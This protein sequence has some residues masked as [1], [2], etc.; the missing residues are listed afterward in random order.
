MRG[1]VYPSHRHL[2]RVAEI[3]VRS[4][5]MSTWRLPRASG[6][7][8]SLLEMSLK[9]RRNEVRLALDFGIQFGPEKH[10]NH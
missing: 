7:P 2:S 4:A 5:T 9:G 10:D 6:S 1:A 3:S 8:S